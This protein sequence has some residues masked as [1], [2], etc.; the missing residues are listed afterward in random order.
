MAF[1]V[2]TISPAQQAQYAQGRSTAA[3]NRGRQGAQNIYQQGLARQQYSDNLQRFNTQQDRTRE[4]LPSN[5]IQRG[6]FNS[7]I[8][9]QALRNYALDRLMGRK[10]L[11][12]NYQQQAAGL[13]FDNRGFE[14]E[15][16][17]TMYNLFGNQYAAQASIASAL[18]G[19]L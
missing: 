11:Q 10:Q 4:Q 16:A 8:Y 7:G 14:D 3:Y 17:D 15:Y 19:I 18:K 6:V 13:V 12:N 5:Y 2:S 9:R 1:T